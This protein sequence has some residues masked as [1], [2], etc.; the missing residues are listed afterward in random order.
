VNLEKRRLKHVLRH[1]GVAE[2]AT[3]ITEQLVLIPLHERL[4]GR[5]ILV[6]A[7]AA[8]QFLIGK[9]AS[10]AACS[11]SRNGPVVATTRT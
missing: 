3:E 10:H 7:A 9:P 5:R 6:S 2:V 4:E 11:G 1:L 8:E